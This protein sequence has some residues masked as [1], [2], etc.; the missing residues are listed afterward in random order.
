MDYDNADVLAGVGAGRSRAEEAFRY[1]TDST[2]FNE[3]AAA[4]SVTRAL[5]QWPGDLSPRFVQLFAELTALGAFAR[6]ANGE[7][8]LSDDAILAMLAHAASF[9]NS[10]KHK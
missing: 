9:F 8:E 5:E 6:T 4:E 7:P 3:S 10:F 2:L 1:A